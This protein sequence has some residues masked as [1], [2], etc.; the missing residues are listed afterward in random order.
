[1]Y[2]A[3]SRPN[4]YPG[5]YSSSYHSS[6]GCGN[7]DE[8]FMVCCL[9]GLIILVPLFVLGVAVAAVALICPCTPFCKERR[10]AW[11]LCSPSAIV[12]LL[13]PKVTASTDEAAKPGSG[14]TASVEGDLPV[15]V[16]DP[17]SPTVPLP[18]VSM[19]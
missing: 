1:M 5:R 3:D 2:I 4:A 16:P 6:Y 9:C 19:V 7:S 18:L 14:T 12:G 15:S 11:A 8:G 10:A 17:D 13:S